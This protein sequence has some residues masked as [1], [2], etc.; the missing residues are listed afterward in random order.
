M[1]SL[2]FLPLCLQLAWNQMGWALLWADRL[3][4]RT[5]SRRSA[6][7]RPAPACHC[8]AKRSCVNP[9]SD[10]R[11]RDNTAV[12]TQVRKNPS[13][14]IY[15]ADPISLFSHRNTT[16]SGRHAS[17]TLR[18]I[19]PSAFTLSL[20]IFCMRW[21]RLGLLCVEISC[22]WMRYI[23]LASCQH[24]SSRR[25]L[26]CTFRCFQIRLSLCAICIFF[27]PRLQ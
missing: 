11:W 5:D 23:F 25:G 18:R 3:H 9:V 16:A 22:T 19:S 14:F 12:C 8:T 17:Q 10:R 15:L 1:Q 27:D 4:F 26:F 13:Y 21:E 20:N 6:P 24:R 7:Q 2:L